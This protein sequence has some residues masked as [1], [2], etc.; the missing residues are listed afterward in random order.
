MTSTRSSTSA[1]RLLQRAGAVLLGLIVAVAI[2]ELALRAIEA[3]PWWRVLPAVHAQFDG[4][5]PATG[6]AHRPNVEGLWIRENRA[7]VRINA[8]GL[9]DRA[10]SD[11][12]PP[13]SVRIAVAGDSITEALQVDESD[14]FTL[15]AERKLSSRGY[16]VEVLNFGLSGAL[17][18]QQLL[19]VAERGLPMGVDGAVFMFAASD[20]LN[21]HMRTD[22]V[23]PAYVDRPSGDME[24]GRS[25]R[26]RLS[27]RM[28]DRWPGRLFFFVVDHSRVA[29]A[30][31]IRTKQGLTLGDMGKAPQPA[32][33]DGCEEMHE[34]VQRLHKLWV[35]GDPQ[36]AARRVDR[37]LS[38]IGKLLGGK[39]AMV[40]LWGFGLPKA[41]CVADMKIREQVVAKARSKAEAAGIAFVDVEAAV[42]A[43]MGDESGFQRL[44]GFGARLGYGHLNP[45][46]HEIYAEVLAEAIEARFPQL[47]RRQGAASSLKVQ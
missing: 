19:F 44:G 13:G 40:A 11:R 8:Q 22:T 23:L 35:D 14:L 4:P 20:F 30:V 6:Y 5:D 21:R 34:N 16:P 33:G 46:G 42:L 9:R 36:W 32:T 47:L 7:R 12:P 3:S 39:P 37:F 38:D 25:Y 31:Y 27:H 24:I 17:P 41:A 28:A 45:W 43:K 10:R 2:M 26:E 29:N 18:L 15:R 1:S